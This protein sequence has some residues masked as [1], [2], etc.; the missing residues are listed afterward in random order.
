VTDCPTKRAAVLGEL[1]VVIST[2]YDAPRIP[3]NTGLQAC[4]RR[5]FTGVYLTK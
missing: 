5:H 1:V 2:A 4:N 3:N